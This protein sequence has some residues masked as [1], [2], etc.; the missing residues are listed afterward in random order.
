M[1]LARGRRRPAPVTS[2]RRVPERRAGGR[3]RWA[4][5]AVR[6]RRHRRPPRPGAVDARRADHRRAD[7]AGCDPVLDQPGPASHRRI[8]AAAPPPRPRL[9]ELPGVTR[10]RPRRGH[11]RRHAA[12]AAGGS[13]PLPGHTRRPRPRRPRD[14]ARRDD[15]RPSAVHTGI[16]CCPTSATRRSTTTGSSSPAPTTGGDSTRTARHPGCGGATPR[17]RRGPVPIGDGRWCRVD[18]CAVPHPH[19]PSAPRARASLFRTPKLQL[20]CRH[21]PAAGIA[22]MASTVRAVRRHRSLRRRADRHT[23]GARRQLSRRPRH[24]SRWRQSHRPAAGAGARLRLQPAEPVLVPRRA[25]AC[26]G[27][28]SPRCTTPTAAGT[29]T[30]CLRTRASPRW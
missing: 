13:A 16:R 20:V 11:L 23:A 21:R 10:V 19:H 4:A 8:G 12:D 30:C 2:M 22:A 25:T 6:R 26:C 17:R 7:G 29:P 27:M 5:A 14:R 1:R 9:V 28:W 24:R 15:L 18:T 3:R